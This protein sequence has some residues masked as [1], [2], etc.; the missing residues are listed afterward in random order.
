MTATM[1]TVHDAHD[2]G[3]AAV[4]LQKERQSFSKQPRPPFS[5]VPLRL[6]VS[7]MNPEG[8]EAKRASVSLRQPSEPVVSM[9]QQTVIQITRA[10][11]IFLR[12]W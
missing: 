12:L 3:E 10:N 6:S 8:G 1:I 5:L 11:V 9:Q 7:G 2:P 4:G